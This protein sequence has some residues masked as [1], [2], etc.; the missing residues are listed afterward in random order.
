MH[1]P[2]NDRRVA[3]MNE[4]DEGLLQIATERFERRLAEE[5]GR[6][7]LD[8]ANA[9]GE[10]RAAL[11]TGLGGLRAEMIE[12][13][14]ELLKWALVIWATQLAAVAAMLALFR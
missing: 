10:M 13:N 4:R 12:R 9:F 1:V 8:M 3:V 14:H 5:T 11:A 6:L 2:I 7:R